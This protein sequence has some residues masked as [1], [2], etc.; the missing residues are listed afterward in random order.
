MEEERKNGKTG[1]MRKRSNKM[2]QKLVN[3]VVD[4]SNCEDSKIGE[5]VQS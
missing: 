3:I 1:R 2:E 4:K 5:I